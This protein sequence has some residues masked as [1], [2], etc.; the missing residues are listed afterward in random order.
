M[1]K[2]RVERSLGAASLLSS[3]GRKVHTINA[4]LFLVFGWVCFPLKTKWSG[5]DKVHHGSCCQVRSDPSRRLSGISGQRADN[6]HDLCL[7]RGRAGPSQRPAD[8]EEAI[9]AFFLVLRVWE[10]CIGR[11]RRGNSGV[12]RVFL[13]GPVRH[14][15]RVTPFSGCSNRCCRSAETQIPHVSDF[16]SSPHF[17]FKSLIRLLLSSHCGWS[18]EV[19][20]A[21]PSPWLLRHILR[22]AL[23][24]VHR[25]AG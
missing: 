17:P 25:L 16:I 20:R 9:E 7:S 3:H 11:Q 23:G 24:S 15:A 21:L 2:A 1:G 4:F 8:G 18:R 22:T 14:V 6:L 12:L 10:Y 5:S 19:R 13:C